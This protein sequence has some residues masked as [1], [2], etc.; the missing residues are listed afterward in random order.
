MPQVNG[1]SHVT[2]TVTDIGRAKGWYSDVLDW[3]SLF[4]GEEE[5]VEYAVGIIPGP[6]VIIGFRQ[7]L[8]GA[9]DIFE[10]GRTGLDHVA[11]GVTSRGD[12]EEWEKRFEEK[13]VT[14]SPIQD[15]PYGHCLNFKDPDS[16]ALEIFAAPGT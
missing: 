14:Y 15:V 6:N 16:I 9:G 12:L 3:Q 7:N 5:G 1:V 4:E 13:G 2:L 11:F 8:N 10:P